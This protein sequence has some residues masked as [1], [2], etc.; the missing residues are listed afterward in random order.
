MTRRQ[1]N[2]QWNVGIA[3]H[4]AQ[5]IPSSK[6]HWKS[7]H[8][9]FLGSRRHPP[10]WLSSKRPNYQRR[11]LII[12]AGSIEGHFEGKTP[13]RGKI[14]KG[15]LFLHDNASADRALATQK[16]LAHLGFQCLHRPPILRIWPLR[17]TT[18]SLDWK[19]NWKV[20][21][22]R[23]TRRSLLPRKPGWTDNSVNFFEWLAKVRAT[24]QKV[25]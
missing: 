16:K 1:S 19:K 14:T 18:C 11:V 25:Y 6:I 8:L 23:P 21:I 4:P 3:A 2:N 24:G 7:S 12:S 22:F 17:T 13:R 10:H 15:V 5:K 20:A 9:D